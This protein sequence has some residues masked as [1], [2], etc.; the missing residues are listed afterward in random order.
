[1]YN[2][3]NGDRRA[4]LNVGAIN[5]WRMV[6]RHRVDRP[7]IK[8]DVGVFGILCAFGSVYNGATYASPQRMTNV[9][10]YPIGTPMTRVS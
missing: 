6:P 9:A 4:L 8:D 3:V 5:Q 2:T 7:H 1:M 10:G